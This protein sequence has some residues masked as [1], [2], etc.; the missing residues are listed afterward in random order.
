MSSLFTGCLIDKH[1]YLSVSSISVLLFDTPCVL[2]CKP[3]LCLKNIEVE[4]ILTLTFIF[5]QFDS[6]WEVFLWEN[7]Y[8]KTLNSSKY[9]VITASY[10]QQLSQILTIKLINT[11]INLENLLDT[12]F[13]RPLATK[14]EENEKWSHGN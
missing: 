14:K 12:N 5:L 13:M 1:I 10:K 2:L 9:C 6:V 11:I 8:Q 7:F 3:F 4:S